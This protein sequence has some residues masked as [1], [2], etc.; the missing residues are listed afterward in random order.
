M[1]STPA[2]LRLPIQVSLKGRINW[3]AFSADDGRVSPCYWLSVKSREVYVG[4][5]GM[6]GIK[7]SLHKTGDAHLSA[8][9]HETAKQ[10]G[11]PAKI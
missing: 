6:S 7:I 4:Q 8:N 11:F 10:W 1:S 9:D 3:Q 5:R 2:P